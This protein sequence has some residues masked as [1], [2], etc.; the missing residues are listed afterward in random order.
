MVLIRKLAVGEPFWANAA[1]KPKEM[2]SRAFV[3]NFF[4]RGRDILENVLKG[5][6]QKTKIPRRSVV[7][8]AEPAPAQDVIQFRSVPKGSAVQN[9][10][11]SIVPKYYFNGTANK[12]GRIFPWRKG[13]SAL[14]LAFNTGLVMAKGNDEELSNYVQVY[15]R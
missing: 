14:L 5:T 1:G 15:A 4:R 12:M 11:R 13:G 10:W 2:A 9:I 7:R 6:A 3:T 8:K